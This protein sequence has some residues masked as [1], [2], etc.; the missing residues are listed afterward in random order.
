MCVECHSEVVASRSIHQHRLSLQKPLLKDGSVF[1]S[2][3]ASNFGFGITSGQDEDDAEIFTSPSPGSSTLP[4]TKWHT[5]D[6]SSL[7]ESARKQPPRTIRGPEPFRK[8]S[9]HSSTASI[10][11]T[12]YSDSYRGTDRS[13]SSSHARRQRHVSLPVY[14]FSYVPPSSDVSVSQ[15]SHKAD[16]SLDS[17]TQC[18]GDQWDVPVPGPSVGAV[19]SALPGGTGVE[20]AS[21]TRLG[22]DEN[23][24][25]DVEVLL[26]ANVPESGFIL[27]YAGMDAN[28]L[29]LWVSCRGLIPANRHYWIHLAYRLTCLDRYKALRISDDTI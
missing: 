25:L 29:V 2:S 8:R 1:P 24:S 18:E 9:R 27:D 4:L 26:V 22:L 17:P 20:P 14:G 11:S 10:I 5:I 12:K 7:S 23:E 21:A 6:P 19:V 28:P 16:R 3:R 15:L 13:P